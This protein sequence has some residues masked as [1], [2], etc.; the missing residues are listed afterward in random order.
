MADLT[1]VIQHDFGFPRIVR[2]KD[3]EREALYAMLVLLG[4]TKH[5]AQEVAGVISLDS[6]VDRSPPTNTRTAV[7]AVKPHWRTR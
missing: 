1:N 7:I 4:A 2:A 6:V 3:A 5:M